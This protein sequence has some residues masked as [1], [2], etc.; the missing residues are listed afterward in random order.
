M[1]LE[2]LY[3]VSQIAA[4]M[5]IIASLIFVGLQVRQSKQQT[6]QANRLAEAQLSESAWLAIGN[7]FHGWYDT[8]ESSEFMARALYTESDLTL[9]ERRRLDMRLTTVVSSIELGHE[10]KRQGL[11]ND[12]LHRRNMRNLYAIMLTPGGQKWWRKVGKN[13]FDNSYRECVNEIADRA[14]SQ[15]KSGRAKAQ[16][17]ESG[18]VA[19]QTN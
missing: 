1:T 7:L 13:Y 8:A 10:L 12:A 18:P 14:T 9:V 11:F 2:S 3:F 16:L 19:D 4:A 17:D 5:A 6:E 15:V